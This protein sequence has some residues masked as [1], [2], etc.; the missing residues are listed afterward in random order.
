LARDAAKGKMIVRCAERNGNLSG[1][2]RPQAFGGSEIG[3]NK[4]IILQAIIEN[5]LIEGEDN[6]VLFT[7][8]T[9]ILLNS[10]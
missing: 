6:M 1:E 7:I 3:Q 4:I 10:P 2:F 9:I 8:D 5:M